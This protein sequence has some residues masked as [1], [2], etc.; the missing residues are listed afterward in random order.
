MTTWSHSCDQRGGSEKHTRD[1]PGTET[2]QTLIQQQQQEKEDGTV[3]A[4]FVLALD[5]IGADT[6]RN[7]ILGG[8]LSNASSVG[9]FSRRWN[10]HMGPA[11]MSRHADTHRLGF[12]LVVVR[13]Q[14]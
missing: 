6:R 1:S 10:G 7:P 12:H 2:A 4:A 11:S 9:T 14:L 3:E 8:D 5:S 13:E